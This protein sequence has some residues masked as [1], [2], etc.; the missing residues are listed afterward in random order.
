[1]LHL[2]D[3][4]WLSPT[5]LSPG[6]HASSDGSRSDVGSVLHSPVACAAHL[7]I[8]L[9]H[10]YKAFGRGRRERTP[11]VPTVVAA[12]QIA[13]GG[14]K[15]NR[16]AWAWA[17]AR[18]CA[19]GGEGSALSG[20]SR[21]RFGGS[22]GAAGGKKLGVWAV[23]TPAPEDQRSKDATE[24]D[25]QRAWKR[26]LRHARPLVQARSRCCDR[27][28]GGRSG[29]KARR[30]CFQT[31]VGAQF[32]PSAPDGDTRGCCLGLYTPREHTGDVPL[33]S[34]TR[35]CVRWCQVST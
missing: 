8:G 32:S 4:S 13:R 15:F 3:G 22:G 20:P 2:V 23:S 35:V 33:I 5:Q 6:S 27:R 18:V 24:M 30:A 31:R 1:V 12:H 9:H 25:G 29:R 16:W 28:G 19:A 7:G 17:W 34:L 21:G 11:R 10:R 14:K 26:T